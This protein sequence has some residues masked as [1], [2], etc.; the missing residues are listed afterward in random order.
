[1]Y[2]TRVSVPFSATSSPEILVS[3]RQ[4]KMEAFG[5][6]LKIKSI[7]G[8]AEAP[9]ISPDQRKLYYHKKEDNKFVLY[10]TRKK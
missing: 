10:M 8:F 1:M 7:T 4:N 3:A 6:P 2:F 9:T 5:S